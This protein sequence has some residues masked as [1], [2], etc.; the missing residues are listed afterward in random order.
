MLRGLFS[1]GSKK[2][3]AGISFRIAALELHTLLGCTTP[4][5]QVEEH[6]FK[7]PIYA[8]PETDPGT[9]RNDTTSCTIDRRDGKSLKITA[10]IEHLGQRYQTEVV[11]ETIDPGIYNVKSIILD[12]QK[13]HLGY[14]HKAEQA[15]SH[16][17]HHH[18]RGAR[19]GWV[20]EPVTSLMPSAIATPLAPIENTLGN[21]YQAIVTSGQ[22]KPS[23]LYAQ[24]GRFNPG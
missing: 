12:N 13:L 17:G 21:F 4:R 15:L 7:G 10:V 22:R 1:L 2:A 24:R 23:L 19:L 5:G 3:P 20:P 11:A 6:T 9:Q 16:I 14:R 18:M 8:A